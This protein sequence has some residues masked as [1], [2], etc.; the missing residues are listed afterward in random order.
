MLGRMR[1]AVAI[2]LAGAL[3]PACSLVIPLDD[4]DRGTATSSSGATGGSSGAGGTC[5]P[6]AHP[7]ISSLTDDFGDGTPAPA[8][9]PHL[10]CS[11]VETGGEVVFAI[12]ADVMQFCWY[13][14]VDTFRLTCDALTFAVLEATTPTQGV[15][16][17]VYLDYIDEN[18]MP[19]TI[20]LILEGGGFQLGR[21]SDMTSLPKPYD[22]VQDRWWRLRE[23]EGRLYFETS[24]D[25]KDFIDLG[26]IPDPAPLE[27]VRV[28]F[29]AGAYQALPNPGTARFDCYNVPAPC[30]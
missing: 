13:Q 19:D 2:A 4:Y 16:T 17:F 23:A 3:A 27:S 14:S 24:P 26:S 22:P 20:N 11:P 21:M 6:G 12:P 5:A 1:S 10:A 8:W 25:G 28:R 18:L 29:G 30:P 15:Q 7:P 9:S